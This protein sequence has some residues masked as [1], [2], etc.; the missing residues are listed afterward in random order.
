M[1]KCLILWL[2]VINN[3]GKRERERD[4]DSCPWTWT[5]RPWESSNP[6]L[7]ENPASFLTKDQET[8]DGCHSQRTQF[9]Y[10]F[11]LSIPF[12]SQLPAFNE[13]WLI[14]LSCNMVLD[15][16]FW[17]QFLTFLHLLLLQQVSLFLSNFQPFTNLIVAL[18]SWF[19]IVGLSLHEKMGSMHLEM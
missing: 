4:L 11:V 14:S 2:M 10:S 15:I 16:D 19:Q 17:K 8:M 6:I 5:H 1:Y 9:I 13:I 12:L 7:P 3:G 18:G